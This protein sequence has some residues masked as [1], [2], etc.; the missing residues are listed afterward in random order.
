MK[1]NK[2]IGIAVATFGVVLSTSVA[3]ALYAHADNPKQIGIGVFDPIVSQDGDINFVI[4]SIA[5]DNENAAFS[6]AHLS[7]AYSFRI[8]ANKGADSVLPL[9]NYTVGD[10]TVTIS[11][12][13][14]TLISNLTAVASVAVPQNKWQDNDTGTANDGKL[15]LAV[16]KNQ[17]N[18]A[19]TCSLTNF[20]AQSVKDLAGGVNSIVSLSLT[21]PALNE[22]T[23]LAI[24]EATYTITAS[25][26]EPANFTYA[27]ITGTQYGWAAANNDTR[28]VPN[29]LSDHGFE[30]MYQ[31][32]TDQTPGDAR[33]AKCIQW[34]QALN[35]GE[36]AWAWSGGDD[37]AIALD[38]QYD[39][40][41]AGGNGVNANFGSG[42][43]L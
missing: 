41:W 11:S 31:H 43:A 28:M 18:T 40:Y 25:W 42:Y 17:G 5:A 35:N 33:G 7:N 20:A 15:D 3:F 2:I 26:V 21:L 8:G 30:W 9:Q 14:T 6:P 22:E 12:S 29:A 36:G 16:Q 4:D 32:Y 37:A 27:Y 23:M 38:K 13:N 19:I 39:V 34:D 10:L 24:G 1:T